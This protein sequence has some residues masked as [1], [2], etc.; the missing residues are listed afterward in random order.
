MQRIIVTIVDQRREGVVY[1]IVIEEQLDGNWLLDYGDGQFLFP[2][3]LEALKFVEQKC[4]YFN[5]NS[6]M[7]AKLDYG[8]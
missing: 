1:S 4:V 6:M 8:D 5:L 7:E 2:Y 3:R